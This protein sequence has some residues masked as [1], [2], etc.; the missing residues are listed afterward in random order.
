MKKLLLI[1]VIICATPAY[2]HN[3]SNYFDNG[4]IYSDSCYPQN[5]TKNSDDNTTLPLKNTLKHGEASTNNILGI[6]ETGDRSIKQ[7]TQN[8]EIK[9]IHY[10]DT[11]VSK[12][13]LP[14][15]F[16]PFYVKKTTT[17]VYGE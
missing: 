12:V 7:A 16:I 3:I 4:Y 8:G 6:I 1:V 15:G 5:V 17:I 2:S 11:K 13:Y 9:K 14:L 10:I